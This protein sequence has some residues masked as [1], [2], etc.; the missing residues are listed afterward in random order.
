MKG[1][2][3]YSDIAYLGDLR[4][5]DLSDLQSILRDRWN[6]HIETFSDYQSVHWTN[7]QCAYIILFTLSG[8]FI[9]IKEEKWI[10]EDIVF[11][12]KEKGV[13]TF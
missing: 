2:R 13:L 3:N 4:Q 1:D 10:K 6:E 9:R 7:S 11:S 5:Y 8:D 12:Y